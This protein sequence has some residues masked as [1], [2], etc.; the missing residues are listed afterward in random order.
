VSTAGRRAGQAGLKI[1][2]L[3]IAERKILPLADYC[4]LSSPL[5]GWILATPKFWWRKMNQVGQ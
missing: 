2:R 4:V 1:L 3:V 5:F